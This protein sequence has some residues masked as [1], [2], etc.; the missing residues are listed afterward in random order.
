[1]KFT[2]WKEPD[3]RYLGC[4]NEYPDHWTQGVDLQDLR[5]HLVVL[6][7]DVR[8]CVMA[9]SMRSTTMNPPAF[10]ETVWFESGH[11]SR[12]LL[13]GVVVRLVFGAYRLLV[14]FR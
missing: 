12:G 10:L 14:H 5:E 4:L 9:G 3:G 7:P 11:P 2:F 6:F 13:S 1:M 8:S